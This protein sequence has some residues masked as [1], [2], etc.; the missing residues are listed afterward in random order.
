MRSIGL[1]TAAALLVAGC[2]ATDGPAEERNGAVEG[3]PVVAPKAEPPAAARAEPAAKPP[4]PPA[5]ADSIPAAFH[6]AYDLSKEAC[7]R[8][9]DMKLR[10][11]A[12]E[13][14]FHESLGEVRRVEPR[15]SGSVR[16]EADYEGEG[17]TWRSMRELSLSDDGATLTISG[18]GT[19]AVRVRCPKGENLG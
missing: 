18:D 2:G 10:V 8:P 5:A 6:G 16:V 3:P 19:R 1:F 12:T 14:R 4:R 11:S 7:G 9:S 15:P 13:L 17:E